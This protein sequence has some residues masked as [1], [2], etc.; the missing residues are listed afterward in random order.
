MS[1][2]ASRNENEIDK[3]KA[4]EC[5][6]IDV[7]TI[8]QNFL[9]TDVYTSTNKPCC[10]LP[11]LSTSSPMGGFKNSCAF[12]INL[13]KLDLSIIMN[14]AVLIMALNSHRTEEEKFNA[15]MIISTIVL[16]VISGLAILNL[17]YY[18]QYRRIEELRS[19]IDKI[20]ADGGEVK[21]YKY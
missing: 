9:E 20:F 8:E 19:K 18:D 16:V 12:F 5:V 10:S 13:F 3:P 4:N 6:L 17:N 7:A 2:L 21:I 11:S 15:A 1:R 14:V